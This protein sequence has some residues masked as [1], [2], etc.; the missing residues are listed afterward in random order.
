MEETITYIGLDVHKETVPVALADGG[1]RGDVR[2]FGQI[3]N[4]PSMLAKLSQPGRT[5][6]FCY[7]AGP[8]GYGIQRQLS[9]AGRD[10]VVVAPS[11][12]HKKP[13]DRI[14]TDRRDASNLARLHRAMKNHLM[15]FCGMPGAAQASSSRRRLRWH[16]RSSIRFQRYSQQIFPCS[17]RHRSR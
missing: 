8:C 5:L 4:T 11:L 7:E 13:G 14:K 17:R 1:G 9:A 16:W 6:K 12:I 2:A 3:V 15:A 10:C